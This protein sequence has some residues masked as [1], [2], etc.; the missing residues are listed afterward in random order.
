MI[1]GILIQAGVL[2]AL[3]GVHL[4]IL[5]TKGCGHRGDEMSKAVYR[6]RYVSGD[7]KPVDTL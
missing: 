3:S 7:L 5:S 6:R 2:A 4:K 1:K